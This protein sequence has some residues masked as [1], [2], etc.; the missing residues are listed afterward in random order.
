MFPE[1]VQV[2][3]YITNGLHSPHIYSNSNASNNGSYTVTLP[4]SLTPGNYFFMVRISN[5]YSISQL[6]RSS[7]RISWRLPLILP[8]RLLSKSNLLNQQLL[9]R[10][11][12]L[13]LTTKT[14]WLGS[15]SQ[16]A[17]W[18]L[19]FLL[20][21]STIWKRAGE[22]FAFRAVCS[23]SDRSYTSS[24]YFVLVSVIAIFFVIS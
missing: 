4:A 5:G 12:S 18:L 21:G 17:V 23:E 22:T 24:L 14:G 11:S 2:S 3:Y 6:F 10:A 9:L 8:K 16:R 7:S 1:T 20:V 13:Y 15:W 19:S